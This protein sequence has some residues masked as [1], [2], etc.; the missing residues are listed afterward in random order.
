MGKGAYRAHACQPSD[1]VSDYKA[2]YIENTV[3]TKVSATPDN[4]FDYCT[5]FKYDVSDVALAVC[6]NGVAP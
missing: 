1:V 3:L 2:H 4:R 6:N 5:G